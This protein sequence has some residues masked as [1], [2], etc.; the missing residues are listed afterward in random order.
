M[1]DGQFSAKPMRSGARTDITSSYSGGGALSLDQA[2]AFLD[3]PGVR[4]EIDALLDEPFLNIGGLDCA[5][6]P[7]AMPSAAR[8]MGRPIAS[9]ILV[10]E[11]LIGLLFLRFWGWV[12]LG[13]GALFIITGFI[14]M[15]G[16]IFSRQPMD[17]SVLFGGLL[18]FLVGLAIGGAGLWFG[19]LRGRVITERCWLCTHG[20]IWLTHGRYDWYPWDEVAEVYCRI[21]TDRP[22]IGIRFDRNTSW[23]S[24][25]NSQA[26]RLMVQYI[27]NRA[28]AMRAPTALKAL[29]EGKT[30]PFGDR[31]L[32]REHLKVRRETL[33]WNQIDRAEIDERHLVLYSRGNREEMTVPLDAIPF[34]SMFTAMVRAIVAHARGE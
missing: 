11:Y 22:A 33:A 20:M 32:N 12:F 30:I 14:T 27:E 2:Q 23:I 10:Q 13:F 21:Q 29:A 25:S 15:V 1:S 16:G 8:A 7:R 19:I 5:P 26:T 31:E 34:P 6:F 4:R 24:F 28:S 18:A 9:A 3:S 17:G